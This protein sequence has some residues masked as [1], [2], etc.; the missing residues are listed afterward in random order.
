MI[1]FNSKTSFNIRNLDSLDTMLESV[2]AI[3][4][5]RCACPIMRTSFIF[6]SHETSCEIA[7]R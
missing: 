3:C 4:H 2:K 1:A 7:G 5:E 6:W